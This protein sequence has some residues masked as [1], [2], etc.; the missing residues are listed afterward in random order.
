MLVLPLTFGLGYGL[1]NPATP[2]APNPNTAF[3][4]GYGGSSV[5]IDQ[6]ARLCFSYVMNKMESGLLGDPRGFGLAAAMYMS[7]A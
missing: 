7:M 2:I 6:D 5:I 1:N 3:W 4:G